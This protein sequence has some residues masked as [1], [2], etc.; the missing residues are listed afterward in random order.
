MPV[1]ILLLLL[2]VAAYFIWRRRTLAL[3]RDCRW[4]QERS[5]H[6][7]RCAFC[8]AISEGA[9]EPTTCQRR[10]PDR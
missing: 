10:S 1:L 3:T 4:R 2:G 6:H 9:V 7:W 5:R 8:G